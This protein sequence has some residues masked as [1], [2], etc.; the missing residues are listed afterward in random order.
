MAEIKPPALDADGLPPDYLLPARVLADR[1][2][3]DPFQAQRFLTKLVETPSPSES[4]YTIM[5]HEIG[6]QGSQAVRTY[7]TIILSGLLKHLAY[8]MDTQELIDTDPDYKELRERRRNSIH[9]SEAQRQ[10][11]MVRIGATELYHFAGRTAVYQEYLSAKAEEADEAEVAS[12]NAT[13]FPR[14]A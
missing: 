11:H 3:D 10:E 1:I 7:R 13:D 2:E 6:L 14:T 8:D 9:M 4:D 12:A 5:Q